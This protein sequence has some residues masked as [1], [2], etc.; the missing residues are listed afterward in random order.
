VPK[1]CCKTFCRQLGPDI[2]YRRH[3]RRP[4]RGFLGGNGSGDAL[5]AP[6]ARVLR[7]CTPMPSAVASSPRRPCPHGAEAAPRFVPHVYT[8][9]ELGP[10]VRATSSY[11]S[12][13]A[14]LSPHA[15][16][17]D[18]AS[19]WCRPPRER[20]RRPAPWGCGLTQRPAHRAQHEIS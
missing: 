1:V 18:T 7:G 19:L 11:R 4:R 3:P 16:R 6:E 5:L 17:A 12:T 20:S 10:L 9:D 13:L 8:H 15:A 2:R 14:N